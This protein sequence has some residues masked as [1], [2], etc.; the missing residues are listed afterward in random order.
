MLVFVGN[1]ID[2]FMLIFENGCIVDY[3]VEVGEEVLK[4]LVEIDEGFYFLG[5]VVLVFYDLLILN[6]NVLFYNIL[7]DENVFCYF[8][9]GNVYVFNLVGGKI[10]FK[11]EFVENGVNVSIIYNDFMIGLVE[12]DIDGI[13]VDGRYE[14]IFCKGNWVF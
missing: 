10:M 3:K 14:F 5:E 9:I 1:I 2:N 12:F 7:F 13:I 8:V 6:I 4:Y 11:E